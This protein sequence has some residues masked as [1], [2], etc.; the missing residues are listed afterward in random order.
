MRR[1]DRRHVFGQVQVGLTGVASKS[2]I[3]A[4]A[5][6]RRGWGS[7]LA[8]G[9]GVEGVLECTSTVTFCP[10]LMPEPDP[11]FSTSFLKVAISGCACIVVCQCQSAGAVV[12]VSKDRRR[13][14]AARAH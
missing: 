12:E 2:V 6:A 8:G 5:P 1:P 11:S 7:A 4:S 9:R 3:I 10:T 14:A 13:R